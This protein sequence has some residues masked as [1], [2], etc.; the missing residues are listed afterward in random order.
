MAGPGLASRTSALETALG[1]GDGRLPDALV[2]RGR[3]V[4][5]R[6][7]ARAALSAEHTV[8]AVAGSTGSGKSSLVNAVAGVEV[9][10]P[11]TRRPTTA[12]ARAAVWGPGADA[13]LDWL[14]V[15]DRVALEPTG[16]VETPG[17]VLLDLPDH[18]SVVTEHRT[19]AEAL[20]ERADLLVWV[21]D[22]QKYADAALHE[23][24]L[25]TLVGHDAVVVV[26]LN[27]VD[28]LDPAE[29]GAV[30]DDLARLVREDGLTEA[31]VVTASARTGAGVDELRDLLAD[32]ARRRS[33]A[34][35][36]LL[37][38][39]VSVAH[40]VVAACGEPV[41]DR[42][43]KAARARLV[44]GLETA[45]GVRTVVDAVRAS[46]VR[47]ARASTGWPLT[48]WV[49]RL[50][51]DPL[52]R[53]GLRTVDEQAVHRPDLV[54]SSMP[55]P[56]ASALA[57]VRLA[58]RECVRTLSAGLPEPWANAVA[59]H[60]ASSA[61]EVPG[62]LDQAVVST[63]LGAARVPLWWRV[64]NVL[65]WVVLAVGAAGLAWLGAIAVAGY[66]QLPDL[67][68]P[69]WGDLPV[70][71]ALAL[72]ALVAG[73]LLALVSRAL[74]SIGA[75]HRATQARRR[76][77]EAVGRVGDEFVRLPIDGELA[78]LARCRTAALIA[79]T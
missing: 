64:V 40:E 12:T 59:A 7:R 75:R 3:E 69:R 17:L 20:V 30:R 4:V 8:V 19:R 32:V 65:Q 23:R 73:I 50:R 33:A 24:Y 43:S 62:A 31:R 56:T 34:T 41:R 74:A 54:A 27:Q 76:L 13:L 38:D 29:V 37:A 55:P 47:D 72:G 77:R 48:R 45:A 51:P 28:R 11:G 57:D 52:R 10:T 53:L 9:A 35:A 26:V 2:A 5:E 42:E 70:P 46:A 49:G 16:L 71:T 1:A 61:D 36:R 79:A 58:V 68:V 22:P 60:A 14:D 15:R 44:D 66:L 25:R 39:V 63:R 21:V 18:D 6:A 78:R 67:P